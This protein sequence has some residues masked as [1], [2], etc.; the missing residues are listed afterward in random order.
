MGNIYFLAPTQKN[1]VFQNGHQ[2]SL[3]TQYLL[4]RLLD[5]IQIWY[6]FTLAIVH[7]LIN[8]WE[9]FIKKKPDGNQ[10]EKYD[11]KK[12][13]NAISAQLFVGLPSNLL[14]VNHTYHPRID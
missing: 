5:C 13:E 12:L 4:N 8:F 10:L 14:W 2:E 6:D 11:P 3:G 1:I 9:S 7:G